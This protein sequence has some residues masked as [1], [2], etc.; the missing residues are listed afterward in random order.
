MDEAFK[1][2]RKSISIGA[3]YVAIGE[4]CQMT[5]IAKSIVQNVGGAFYLLNFEK[6]RQLN[7]KMITNPS[8]EFSCGLWNIMGI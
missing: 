4:K 8:L 2:F 3:A 1:T 7:V 6:A 5:G